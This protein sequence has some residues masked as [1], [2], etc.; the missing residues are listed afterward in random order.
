MLAKNKS[1]ADIFCTRRHATHRGGTIDLAM[2]H[3]FQ[4]KLHIRRGVGHYSGHEI[5][6]YRKIKAESRMLAQKRFR[7]A[8]IL[9]TR[10]HAL[11]GEE[12]LIWPSWI[13]SEK[14]S[15][16]LVVLAMAVAIT[17]CIVKCKRQ[18]VGC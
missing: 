5:L 13:N 14:G 10:R 16:C 2:L 18:K 12:Q 11:T 17:F 4:K 8:E 15:T 3:Q 9:S 6:N 1:E 7:N